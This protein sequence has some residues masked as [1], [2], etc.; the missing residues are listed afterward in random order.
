MAEV[1]SMVSGNIQDGMQELKSYTDA[2]VAATEAQVQ[3]LRA[4]TDDHS[5]QLQD[6]KAQLAAIQ[7]S[8]TATAHTVVKLQDA[9]NDEVG[10]AGVP[11]P[12]YTRA[13]NYG[14]LRLGTAQKAHKKDVQEA[15][16]REWLGGLFSADQWSISGPD[17][18][19]NWT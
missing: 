8:Q 5:K 17:T 13:P 2:R 15:A 9:V 16:D 10:S 6:I 3:S 1:N 18:G 19:S 7:S 11:D 14:I 12:E 4:T